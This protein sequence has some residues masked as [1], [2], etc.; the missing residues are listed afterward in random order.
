MLLLNSYCLQN[1][2]I[3]QNN[4]VT[5]QSVVISN[6][7][8]TCC[9]SPVKVQNICETTNFFMNYFLSRT[10]VILFSLVLYICLMYPYLYL[11]SSSVTFA[12]LDKLVFFL[13]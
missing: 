5:L 11:I 4:S 7:F 10:G 6:V 8:V 2:S 9:N 3:I 13:I 12:A 1:S